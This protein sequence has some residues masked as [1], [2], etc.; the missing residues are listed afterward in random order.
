MNQP[1]SP[2]TDWENGDNAP[3]VGVE[4]SLL[5]PGGMIIST[6]RCPQLGKRG[7]VPTPGEVPTL[8]PHREVM[9]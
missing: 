1:V 6:L 9:T 3:P 7:R 5:P 4:K 2:V 8:G